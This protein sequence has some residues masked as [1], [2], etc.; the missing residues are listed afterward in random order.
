MA[1]ETVCN[2]K[3]AIGPPVSEDTRATKRNNL[4]A[5]C[6]VRGTVTFWNAQ[7]GVWQIIDRNVLTLDVFVYLTTPGRSRPAR[8][9]EILSDWS[10]NWISPFSSRD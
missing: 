4:P 1:A 10:C 6:V 5:N 8:N 9:P 3:I 2:R 7:L